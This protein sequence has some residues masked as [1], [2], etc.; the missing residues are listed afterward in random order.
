[1]IWESAAN[2]A[3]VEPE[4]GEVG[5]VAAG[6]A[7]TGGGVAVEAETAREAMATRV[8]EA[9]G[10]AEA[11]GPAGRVGLETAAEWTAPRARV[12]AEEGA[13]AAEE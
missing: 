10:P 2:W 8:R 12:V 11:A 13:R 9:V 5:E 3:S 4:M 7:G 1:V 6:A